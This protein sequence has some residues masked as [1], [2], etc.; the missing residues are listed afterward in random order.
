[1]SSF[2]IIRW[3]MLAFSTTKN[4]KSYSAP[5]NRPVAFVGRI[6]EIALIPTDSG[7]P[8]CHNDDWH[9]N[10]SIDSQSVHFNP[11]RVRQE[12]R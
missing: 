8:E 9:D 11:P 7:V 5:L 6:M 4:G 10:V 1:M 3:M 12:S 2:V